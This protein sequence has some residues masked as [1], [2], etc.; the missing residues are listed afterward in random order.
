ML[1]PFLVEYILVIFAIR[2]HQII[3]VGN[4]DLF[5]H[6]FSFCP[7]KNDFILGQYHAAQIFKLPSPEDNC[8]SVLAC[9]TAAVKSSLKCMYV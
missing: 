3:N 9:H 6:A 8:A 2:E 1:F 4:N 7:C 5:F